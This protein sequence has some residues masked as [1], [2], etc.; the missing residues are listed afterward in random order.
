MAGRREPMSIVCGKRVTR[1]SDFF[2]FGDV[3][4]HQKTQSSLSSLLLPY[5]CF[6]FQVYVYVVS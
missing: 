5:R 6:P 1:S 3:S 4:L 2:L